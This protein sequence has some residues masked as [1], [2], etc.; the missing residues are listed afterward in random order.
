MKREQQKTAAAAENPPTDRTEPAD[1]DADGNDTQ[2]KPTTLKQQVASTTAP[3]PPNAETQKQKQKSKTE[4]AE[5]A[6]DNGSSHRPTDRQNRA[7][8][9]GQTMPART[10]RTRA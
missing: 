7:G 8:P 1:S 6:D 9:H 5:A 10:N 2:P 4:K 3:D